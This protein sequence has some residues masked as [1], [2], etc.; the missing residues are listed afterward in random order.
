MLLRQVSDYFWLWVASAMEYQNDSKCQAEAPSCKKLRLQVSATNE[1]INLADVA[2]P[3]P[4]RGTC[5]PCSYDLGWARQATE[6]C[7][8]VFSSWKLPSQDRPLWG[9]YSLLLLPVY[10]SVYLFRKGLSWLGVSKLRALVNI[11]GGAWH[12]YI[13]CGRAWEVWMKRG[14]NPAWGGQDHLRDLEL[15]WSPGSTWMGT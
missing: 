4:G 6:G 7:C 2:G 5:L 12:S 8:V 9:A 11:G 3:S 14:G 10:L 13:P 15:A 1:W